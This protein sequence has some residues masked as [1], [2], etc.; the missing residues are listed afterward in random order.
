MLKHSLRRKRV[1]L[2]E[3]NWF[4]LFFVLLFRLFGIHVYYLTASSFWQKENKI[5]RL[6]DL[7]IVWLNYQD[8]PIKNPTVLSLA[9]ANEL[10]EHIRLFLIQTNIFHQLKKQIG[11]SDYEE[12]SLST[13][14]VRSLESRIHMLAELLVFAELIESKTTKKGWLCI[15]NDI[16]SRNILEKEGGWKNLCPRW[17]TFLSFLGYGLS[18]ALG[19]I[20]SKLMSLNHSIIQKMSHIGEKQN[21]SD[22][23]SIKKKCS[24]YEI[25]YFPH[26]V[27]WYGDLF[28][29]IRINTIRAWTQYGKNIIV[30]QM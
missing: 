25:I 2:L 29:K 30:S 3:L 11:L 15:P 5:I 28:L 27:I 13:V 17:C 7:G 26:K 4:N 24:K 21:I 23:I 10:R 6:N 12:Q 16:L 19:I 20:F 9:K 22:D 18:V 14:V 8:V 1:Y